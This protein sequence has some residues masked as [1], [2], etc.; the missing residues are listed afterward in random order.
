MN[1][2]TNS[3]LQEMS[4]TAQH[5]RE[6]FMHN[7]EGLPQACQHVV[8]T[9]YKARLENRDGAPLLGE[10]APWI[11]SDILSI[12]SPK[13]AERVLSPWMDLYIYTLLLDD[14]I[15]TNDMHTSTPVLIASS[16]IAQR[17]I[18]KLYETFPGN[19]WVSLKLDECFIE[20]ATAA[21]DEIQ[22]HRN[23]VQTYSDNDIFDIGKKFS[24]LHLC[25]AMLLADSRD[26]VPPDSIL[27]P[28]SLLSSGMQL[29]DDITD[30]HDDWQIHNYTPLLTETFQ[31]LNES[32]IFSESSQTNLS[33]NDI[34][35][36]MIL[37]GSLENSLLKA[38]Q[39]LT[40]MI[41]LSSCHS[42]SV[43]ARFFFQLLFEAGSFRDLVIRAREKLSQEFIIGDVSSGVPF[44]PCEKNPS[45]IEEV[46]RGIQIIA[47]GC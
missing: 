28:V 15:D 20:M 9:K 41:E 39:M 7:L 47:Q 36:A 5:A 24:I 14:I 18:R 16:L 23:S 45:W 44:A 1:W 43:T 38:T 21:I 11:L 10:C 34:L 26:K 33:R 4:R 40:Q 2:I 27:L 32:S 35:A 30:W 17:G 37:S 29:L 12:D 13:T 42:H 3:T 8:L 6:V 22:N 31:F 46:D 19:S 25:G